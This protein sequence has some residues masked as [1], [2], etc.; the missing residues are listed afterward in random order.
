MN[1]YLELDDKCPRFACKR[2]ISD[3][4]EDASEF[5]KLYIL[6]EFCYQRCAI[7]RPQILGAGYILIEVLE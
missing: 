1:K 7:V 5:G 4:T 6:C 2:D 3:H